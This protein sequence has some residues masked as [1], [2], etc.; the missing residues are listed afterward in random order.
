MKHIRNRVFIQILLPTV[1]IFLLLVGGG[2][3]YVNQSYERQVITRKSQEL[4][5]AS[6]AVHNWLVARIS[7][8]VQISRTPLVRR[9]ERE[10]ILAFL[11]EERTRLSFI[12]DSF[13]FIEPDGRYYGTGGR[14]GTLERADF[15]EDF[16][17][18]G[19]SFTYRGP[20]LDHPSFPPSLLVAVAVR[21]GGR[22]RG[23]LAGIIPLETF[24]RMVGYF[25]REEFDSFMMVN[26]RSIIITH[27]N[28]RMIG[29]SER[30]EYGQSFFADTRWEDNMVF[31]SVLRTTWKLVAFSSM[32]SLLQ[33]VRQINRI[34]LL[35]FVLIV[36][37]IGLVSRAISQRVA[38]PVK[39]LTEGVHAIME[40]NYRQRITLTTRDELQELAE[41]FNRLSERLVHLRTEDRFAFLGHISARVAHEVRKP[42]H[43]IQLAVQRLEQLPGPAATPGPAEGQDPA[44][45]PGSAR[46][47]ASAPGQEAPPGR[48]QEE[49]R[50]RE[51]LA[52]HL[53]LIRG[54][55]TNA[56][57]FVAEILNFARPEELNLIRYPLP[58]LLEKVVR[59]YEMVA[60]ERGIELEYRAEADDIHP[61]YM[62]IIK[63]E[64]AISNLLQN[65]VEAL[66]ESPAPAR[67]TVTLTRTE[68]EA[69]IVIED[70][71][72]GFRDDSIDKL[73]DPYFTTRQEGTGLGMSISYRI[74]SAHLARL[75]L[76][77]TSE[78]HA[79]VTIGIP[80]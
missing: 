8:L 5:R 18:E 10:R 38:R 58:D 74:L 48:D 15:L 69:V 72:P 1:I 60:G 4:D 71:G 65:S 22:F 70:T 16:A 75:S 39:E 31:V 9:G 76:E 20:V 57:R 66:V 73:L 63:M 77:N 68:Q 80:L 51:E 79:R 46:Q 14:Q 52:R 50:L 49:G 27:S 43:I 36:G 21:D 55:V 25:T 42:L 78:H 24:R 45:F 62:D 44:A 13:Y 32:D 64:Q 41:A 19:Q 67:I 33:P 37:L 40:G 2:L 12:F 6:R 29:R 59:K 61:F 53:Q 7:T 28:P 54:E 17:R 34:I 35:F 3:Y 26:P 23:S 56:D 47:G 30:G 11:S